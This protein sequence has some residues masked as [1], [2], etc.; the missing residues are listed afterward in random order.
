MTTSEKLLLQIFDTKNRI[1]EQVRQQTELYNRHLASKAL[2]HG[3]TPPSWLFNSNNSTSQELSKEDLISELLPPRPPSR[4]PVRYSVA[5]S[6]QYSKPFIT[7][8][9]EVADGFGAEAHE[10]QEVAQNTSNCI[11]ECDLSSP[12]DFVDV[13]I[14][15]IYTAPDQ[16]LARIQRSKSRQ[17]AIEQR[18]SAK[19]Q[20]KSNPGNERTSRVSSSGNIL[21]ALDNE[22]AGHINDSNILSEPCAISGAKQSTCYVSNENEIGACS[23]EIKLTTLDPEQVHGVNEPP[24]S[25]EPLSI[26]SEG[27][28]VEGKSETD[29]ENSGDGYN[30]NA[31]PVAISERS[32]NSRSL[33]KKT[34]RNSEF[35]HKESNIFNTGSI[36]SRDIIE[37]DRDI[38][39]SKG[40]GRSNEK[41]TIA[42]AENSTSSKSSGKSCEDTKK[43]ESGIEEKRS[44]ATSQAKSNSRNERTP[45]A[46]SCGNILLAFDYEQS[47]HINNS[48]MLSEPCAISGAK[49][50]TCYLS[51]EDDIGA[52]SNEIKLTSLDSEQV[53]SINDPPKSAEPLSISSEGCRVK[54][55]SE[56][57]D[58]KS[59]DGYNE[60]AA[61]DAL[62]KRPG[63][64]CSLE[65]KTPRNSEVE[66]NES[67]IF[68]K[69]S[70]TSRDIVEIDRDIGCSKGDGHSNEK[71][72]N[73]HAKSSTS[74]KSSGKSCEDTASRKDESRIEE[75]ESDAHVEKSSTPKKSAQVESHLSDFMEENY[76]SECVPGKDVDSITSG[77]DPES[78]NNQICSFDG[79][80]KQTCFE[81]R[82]G[83]WITP[84]NAEQGVSGIR[85]SELEDG[86]PQNDNDP[87]FLRHASLNKASLPDENSYLEMMD[88]GTNENLHCDSTQ[89]LDDSQFSVVIRELD[90]SVHKRSEDIPVISQSLKAASDFGSGG[91]S[92]GQCQLSAGEK[93]LD[94]DS[95]F[96]RAQG[97]HVTLP[98]SDMCD[99]AEQPETVNKIE[100]IEAATE[101][102]AETFHLSEEDE[103][104]GKSLENSCCPFL[105]D[106]VGVPSDSLMTNKAGDSAVQ[107]TKSEPR[108]SWH[109]E[110]EARQ[111]DGELSPPNE[112]V[113]THSNPSNTIDDVKF[114]HEQ[115]C[116][117]SQELLVDEDEILK[118]QDLSCM[119]MKSVI[120][121]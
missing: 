7:E 15:N 72:S 106:V 31:G 78:F 55:K 9:Q 44:S 75:K 68:N 11:P 16:S 95:L 3:K 29:N 81:N 80:L 76:F 96:Q 10:F 45:R 36:T 103:C 2:L 79:L 48:N 118:F 110:L 24:R 105:D 49:Q 88:G 28:R 21:F 6:S 119:L 39:C 5:G 97:D 70:I 112:A 114:S 84:P 101:K 109:S 121:P 30:E 25:A 85:E 102:L 67:N 18:N 51:N 41:G 38:V 52:C 107:M 77:N 32:G 71:S 87:N 69:G 47:G 92:F 53:H 33:E 74:S 59:G 62:S 63:N 13:R 108:R 23:N 66:D 120:L 90:R 83:N 60:N 56:T 82:S 91:R 65:K 98:C 4:P 46:S 117:F 27:F 93:P 20:A 111:N 113:S 54:G 35:D 40:D 19:S 42:H 50:S 26:S 104:R 58:E 57:D 99:K 116:E 17:R 61:P 43:E 8:F 37:V 100:A 22:Q 73:S 86:Q 14:S 89:Q 94:E 1:I 115:G 64:S 34:P 12:V